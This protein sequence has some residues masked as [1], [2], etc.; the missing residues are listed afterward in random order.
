MDGSLKGLVAAASV[1]VIAGG[2]WFAWGE[3]QKLH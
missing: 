3:W 2:G 1:V